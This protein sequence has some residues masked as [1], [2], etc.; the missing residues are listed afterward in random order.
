MSKYCGYCGA[1]NADNAKFC[2]KCGKPLDDVKVKSSKKKYIAFGIGI[3]ALVAIVFVVFNFISGQ[4]KSIM[5]ADDGGFL[6]TEYFVDY[7]YS[8]EA[9]V[10]G[11][12]YKRSSIETIT[13]LD[14]KDVDEIPDS[15]WDVSENQ[16]ESVVAWVEAIDEEY[17]D[18]YIAGKD[19]VYANADSRFLFAGYDNLLELNF[20]G[21]FYTDEVTDM[22]YMFFVA[23]LLENLDVSFFITSNVTNMQ[24]MFYGCNCIDSIDL[25][26]F[27]T[28]N[29]TDMSFMFCDCSSLVAVDLSNFDTSNVT[30]MIFMF[31][32]CFSLQSLNLDSFDTANVTSMSN[33]FFHCASLVSLDLSSF[34]TSNVTDMSY[35]FYCCF[36][37]T[38]LD[39]S[40]FDTSN[41]KDMSNM[42]YCCYALNS[43]NVAALD[44][45][46]ADTTDMFRGTNI[47]TDDVSSDTTESST[48][49][50]S[51]QSSSVD[52]SNYETVLKKSIEACN[53]NDVTT[54]AA[55][56]T[57]I[58]DILGEE[59]ETA[60]QTFIDSYLDYFDDDI[61]SQYTITYEITS[62]YEL[63]DSQVETV[64]SQMAS[65]DNEYYEIFMDYF[66][67]EVDSIL[68]GEITATATNGSSSVEQKI[69]I[70]LTE[71][72]GQWK[73]FSM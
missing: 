26:S 36:A 17:Y 55:I 34:D 72:S 42:F 73:F 68:V 54:L 40:S 69:R 20:N 70:Y 46:N 6:T 27:D 21:C 45:S 10:L 58:Y 28:S 48:S 15:A 23:K 3:V 9:T 60:V 56:S 19:G 39:L 1:E 50:S 64:K 43:S 8:D 59:K 71:E 24:G 44:T 63:T 16:D 22:S 52:T 11:S 30:D 7:Y 29:V 62:T 14:K 37:L 67:N 35:M 38:N 2:G 33:M 4:Q 12:S 32:D 65:S 53:D 41:V 25:S 47:A 31:Y 5:Q 61:G 51:T 13:F 57:G 49:S 66:D 18:L